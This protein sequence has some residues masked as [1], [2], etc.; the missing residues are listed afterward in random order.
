MI[1]F[2]GIDKYLDEVMENKEVEFYESVVRH[3]RKKD[4]P[5]LINSN[6]KNIIEKLIYNWDDDC[7]DMLIDRF[8]DE[9]NIDGIQ[10]ILLKYKSEKDY[11]KI[12]K[13][14]LSDVFHNNS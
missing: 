2:S 12:A 4:N 8:I 10:S 9:Y 11:E 5:V 6:N 13:S 1:L 7:L 14:N 3:G